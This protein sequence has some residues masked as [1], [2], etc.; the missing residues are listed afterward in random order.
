ME[1]HQSQWLERKG[2]GRPGGQSHKLRHSPY[3]ALV[4][5]ALIGEFLGLSW[6]IFFFFM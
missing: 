4:A 6:L 1:A 3:V 2:P 5:V